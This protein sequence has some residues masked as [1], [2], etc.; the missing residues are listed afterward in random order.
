MSGNRHPGPKTCLA[1]AE[2]TKINDSEPLDLNLF[3]AREC[4][5]RHG[6][7]QTLHAFSSD[8]PWMQNRPRRS[9]ASRSGSSLWFR[10]PRIRN[11]P[12][13]SGEI[14]KSCPF[15]CRLRSRSTT[16]GSSRARVSRSMP[17]TVFGR[18]P[19]FAR[20]SLIVRKFRLLPGG[21]SCIGPIHLS[22]CTGSNHGLP[23]ACLGVPRRR[24]PFGIDEA[25][26][27]SIFLG[28]VRAV[29][30][31]PPRSGGAMSRAGWQS[32]A[33]RAAGRTC[34]QGIERMRGRR[35]PLPGRRRHR[36]QWQH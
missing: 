17:A 29:G 12:I 7:A 26:C 23:A 25:I 36:G 1:E 8:N 10:A 2:F 27:R 19:P 15:N 32:Q 18:C 16:A 3:P 31:V 9:G 21:E 13:Q 24:G 30:H 14:W 4:L 11:T 20:S 22:A 33:S 5:V 35:P 6:L 28:I 34:H